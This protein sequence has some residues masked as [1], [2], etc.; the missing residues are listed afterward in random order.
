V[1]EP[2]GDCFG[3]LRDCCTA[4]YWY[5]SEGSSDFDYMVYRGEG[6][7]EVLAKKVFPGQT[8]FSNF[9]FSGASVRISIF[10]IH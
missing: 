8:L 5:G 6:W 10:R 2:Y 3:V 7:C 9:L 4:L 1:L